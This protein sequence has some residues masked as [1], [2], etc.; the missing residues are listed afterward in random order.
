MCHSLYLSNSYFLRQT[1][2]Y[3]ELTELSTSGQERRRLQKAMV[4]FSTG[5]CWRGTRNE[6]PRRGGAAGAR[7]SSVRR[8]ALSADAPS[9]GNTRGNPA[10]KKKKV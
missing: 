4:G 10:T 9:V 8:R 1:Q 5:C 3:P 6:P 7:Q 2:T